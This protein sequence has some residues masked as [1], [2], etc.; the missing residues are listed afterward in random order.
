MQISYR[1]RV[2]DKHTGRFKAQSAAVNFV[3]NHC[4]E[5][6]TRAVNEGR[7]WLSCSDLD[8]MTRG[9]TNEGL[10]PHSQAAQQLCKQ[11]DTS[12]KPH[13]KPWL[14]WRKTYGTRRSLGSAPFNHQALQLRA[15]AFVFRRQR[16]DV[17]LHRPLPEGAKIGCGPCSQDSRGRW[18]ITVP[19]EVQEATQAV[20][21]RV[22]IDLRTK[23]LAT[24]SD[25]AK[26][27]APVFCR[28]SEAKL[29]TSQRARKSKQVKAIHANIRNRR[30]DFLHKQ[31]AQ[32]AA[33]VVPATINLMQM[34]LR[35][36]S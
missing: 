18:H 14:G 32:M 11:Y 4:N 36:L 9:V 25:G 3:W 28:A 1:Y 24:L 15:G 17:W 2:K 30:K 12:R 19:V 34:D 26:L 8:R 35:S 16:Y 33:R 31:T 27:A 20:N 22:G 23:T 5:V 29:A 13:S 10:D 7:R 6:Q 21:D